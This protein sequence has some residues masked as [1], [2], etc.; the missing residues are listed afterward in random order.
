MTEQQVK[1][2]KVAHVAC[3]NDF[4]Y[5]TRYFFKKLYRRKWAQW[6]HLIQICD[7]MKD[8]FD[9][10]TKR[11]IV[12]CA[13]RYGKTELMVK[14]AI[15]YGLAL[16]PSAKFIHV[17]YSDDLALDNSESARDIVCSEEYQ[18]LFP[19]VKLKPSSKGKKKWY[20]EAGG[21]VY[22]VS[23][24]GQI[25]GFGAGQVDEEDDDFEEFASGGESKAP[26]LWL[27]KKAKFA[28]AIIMDDSNKVDDADSELL[29]NRVN[30]RFDSTISNRVNSR[31][32]PIING[33]QRTHENDLS[34][35]LI[36]KQPD[37]WRVLSLPSIKEDGT[38]LCPDKH[39]IEELRALE[40]HNDIVFHRQHMQN[41]KPR[42]GLLFP[43]QDLHFY[44][45]SDPQMAAA[46][47][48]PDFNYIPADPANEGGDDFA[49]APFKLVGNKIY[50]TAMLYNT[51][52]ADHNELSLEEMIIAEKAMFVGVEAIFGW[53]ETARRVRDALM[54]RGWQG[55]FRNLR[56]RTSKHT[57]IVNRSAFIRNN[58]VFRSDWE[59]FP[60]YAKFM[61]N[62]TSYLKI[63]EPGAKN[64]H[65]DAPDLC[66]MAGVY[67]EKNFPHLWALPPK[68]KINSQDEVESQVSVE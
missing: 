23:F 12:N 3:L 4:T 45:P 53:K 39:T 62:L 63:Q 18:L 57:R 56:P 54:E 65:D 19:Y 32:T 50:V 68:G 67:Y 26:R 33:Q 6:D 43:I 51:M 24:G 9:G 40:A 64:K 55:D 1:E 66:E 21:G 41:P 20:T 37:V 59:N 5:F 15:A 8:V 28:G 7:A 36:K 49:A 34:G 44:D 16:N 52:G 11:L 47:Q 22:A 42:H 29:R 25:T 58:M 30:E 27:G 48:D 38:A 60:Q 35:Y 46:L 14:M 2:L 10:N 31:N 17:T 61:R 13:P